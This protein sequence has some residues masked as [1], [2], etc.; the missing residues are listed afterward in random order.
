MGGGGVVGE[1]SK[2][3][4]NWSIIEIIYFPTA[5][6]NFRTLLE[7]NKFTLSNTVITDKFKCSFD[8]LYKLTEA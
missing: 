3:L 5:S 4:L 7:S 6:I 2:K 8:F 1:G